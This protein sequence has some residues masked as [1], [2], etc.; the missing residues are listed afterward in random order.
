LF[1]IQHKPRHVRV[2][3]SEAQLHAC[4]AS[5]VDGDGCSSLRPGRYTNGE[6]NPG[7]RWS[8]CMFF[9]VCLDAV[10]ERKPLQFSEIQ[11]PIPG[12][13]VRNKVALLNNLIF[14]NT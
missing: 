13:P 4:L 9:T 10:S 11:P 7:V 6:E 14:G 1:L 2:R 5:A 3:D 8:E 12:R